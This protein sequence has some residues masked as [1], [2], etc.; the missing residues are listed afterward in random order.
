MTLIGTEEGEDRMLR[1]KSCRAWPRAG[2]ALRLVCLVCLVCLAGA[3]CADVAAVLLADGEPAKE[4]P[5]PPGLI[6]KWQVTDEVRKQLQPGKSYTTTV[7]QETRCLA[8]APDGTLALGCNDGTIRL[9]DIAAGKQVRK[10]EGA[11]TW[12]AA[13]AI[14]PDGKTVAGAAGKT[15]HLWDAASGQALRQLERLHDDVEQL[16]FSPDGRVLAS[17]DFGD[18]VRWWDPAT[19][20]KTGRIH[21]GGDCV[22]FSPDGKTVAT[23]HLD[24]ELWDVATSKTRTLDG[25]GIAS[26]VAFSPDGKMLA[27]GDDKKID[28]WDVGSGAVARSFSSPEARFTCLGFSPDGR[29]LAAGGRDQKVRVWEVATGKELR[30]F[31]GHQFEVKSLAFAPAGGKLATCSSDVVC[32]WDVSGM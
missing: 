24:V 12:I 23:G 29:L 8:F 1:R 32:L 4:A 9:R 15:V 11:K 7:E 6:A 18:A 28:L 21:Q 5:P 30:A 22:A 25:E 10:L 20:K 3:G 27:A 17:A 26:F 19:G 16:A 13:L 14:S 31:A 2:R